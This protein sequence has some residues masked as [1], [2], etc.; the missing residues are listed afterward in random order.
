MV[1][2]A[3]FRSGSV[4]VLRPSFREGLTTGRDDVGFR[5]GRYLYGGKMS[6]LKRLLHKRITQLALALVFLFIAV[7]T[8]YAVLPT[9]SLNSPTSFPVDI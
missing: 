4:T 7:A 9:I 2:G 6:K 8:V 3:N 1:K 5:V